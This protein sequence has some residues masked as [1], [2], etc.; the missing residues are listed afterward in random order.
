VKFAVQVVYTQWEMAQK[1]DAMK[2]LIA[3]FWVI[4][5]WPIL[6]WGFFLMFLYWIFLLF[7]LIDP[8]LA[9]PCF[10]CRSDPQ[11]SNHQRQNKRDPANGIDD[12]VTFGEIVFRVTFLY[13]PL[14]SA[15]PDI[16]LSASVVHSTVT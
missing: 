10:A 13:S 14:V 6:V 16:P 5:G 9:N 8:H 1:R 2:T 7:F 3:I 4:P 15:I 11:A 12:M